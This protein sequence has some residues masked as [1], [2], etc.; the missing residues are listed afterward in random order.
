MHRAAVFSVQLVLE[1]HAFSNAFSRKYLRTT[2]PDP[3]RLESI[4]PR[5]STFMLGFPQHEV[6][7]FR[8][9]DHSAIRARKRQRTS[10]GGRNER[11]LGRQLEDSDGASDHKAHA[12]DAARAGVVVA[13]KRDDSTR[14]CQFLNGRELAD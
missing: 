7:K 4:S 5:E 9:R 8:G 2:A 3:S 6:R 10:D 14:F 11:A 12:R 13:A 1:M